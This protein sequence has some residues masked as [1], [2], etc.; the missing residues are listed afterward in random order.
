MKSKSVVAPKAEYESPSKLN[1]VKKSCQ[2]NWEYQEVTTLIQ[3]K[4]NE[5]LVGLEMVDDALPTP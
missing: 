2:P 3:V 5:Y 4:K 1:N